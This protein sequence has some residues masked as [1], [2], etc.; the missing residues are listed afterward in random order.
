MQSC[1]ILYCSTLTPNNPGFCAVVASTIGFDVGYFFGGAIAMLFLLRLLEIF[2]G[3]AVYD[4]IVLALITGYH[5]K[6]DPSSFDGR[7]MREMQAAHRELK[8]QMKREQQ[9]ASGRRRRDV[10][11]R[12]GSEGE[13]DIGGI[14]KK[15]VTNVA[16]DVKELARDVTADITDSSVE[17][18]HRDFHVF[19]VAEAKFSRDYP[20]QNVFYVGL[21]Y[22][23]FNVNASATKALFQASRLVKQVEGR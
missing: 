19:R 4:L 5:T 21:F 17:I 1:L 7:P 2:L 8:A 6:P 3:S 20:D 23:W 12:V 22:R 11:R 18:V 9:D 13:E 15:F 10:S 16:R 14:L